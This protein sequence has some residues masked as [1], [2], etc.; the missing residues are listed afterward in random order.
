MLIFNQCYLNLELL[1]WSLL[2]QFSNKMKATMDATEDAEDTTTLNELDDDQFDNRE[3]SENKDSNKKDSDKVDPAIAES[4][5]DIVEEVT[6]EV[7]NDSGIPS[8][9]RAEV[10]LGQFSIMKVTALSLT[11]TYYL[12]CITP[13][14]KP[15]QT[16]I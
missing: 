1:H 4:D 12:C 11:Q 8:L 10:S 6:A 5:A 2:S 9:T 3:E 16:D 14:M 15:H 7:A 13:T